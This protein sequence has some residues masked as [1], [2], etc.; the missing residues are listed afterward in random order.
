MILFSKELYF[1]EYF[2]CFPLNSFSKF[3]KF[4]MFFTLF[5]QIAEHKNIL[6]D[7]YFHSWSIA[8]WLNLLVDDCQY[9]NITKL[10]KE[11]KKHWVKG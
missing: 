3:E 4:V 2:F 10:K 6:I 7:F 11:K 9:V 1:V 5:K 8:K